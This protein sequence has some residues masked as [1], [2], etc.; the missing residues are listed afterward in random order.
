[1]QVQKMQYGTENRNFSDKSILFNEV[2]WSVIGM[3]QKS[4]E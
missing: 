2:H 3:A 4:I 1:M